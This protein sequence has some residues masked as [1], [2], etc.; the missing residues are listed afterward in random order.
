MTIE[1]E[2]TE[3][4]ARIHHGRRISWAEFYR[5]RP[6]LKTDNDNQAVKSNAA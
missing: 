1:T 3:T 5:H 4:S 2:P 6:D